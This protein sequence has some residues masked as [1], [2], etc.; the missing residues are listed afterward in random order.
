MPALEPIPAIEDRECRDIPVARWEALREEYVTGGGSVEE[1]ATRHG[2]PSLGTVE[3]RATAEGW[4]AMRL[5]RQA[6]IRREL[7]NGPSHAPSPPILSTDW[8]RDEAGKA[9]ADTIK[10]CEG[11][12][13]IGEKIL[14]E[15]STKQ[16]I[17]DITGLCQII[18]QNAKIFGFGGAQSSRKQTAREARRA[19][20]IDPPSTPSDPPK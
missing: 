13:V 10:F 2:F 5:E 15:G 14:T 1:C 9:L 17:Q 11:L 19:R 16:D 12:R 6:R 8:A 7:V 3:N 18:G 4:N 20:V